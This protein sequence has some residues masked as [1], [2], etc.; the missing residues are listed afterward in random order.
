MDWWSNW[1]SKSG[2]ISIVN[3]GYSC[4]SSVGG[5]KSCCEVP[6]CMR[7]SGTAH[8]SRVFE[9]DYVPTYCLSFNLIS[10]SDLLEC[11]SR[12]SILYACGDSST[13]TSTLV[14]YYNNEIDAGRVSISIKCSRVWSITLE[15]E[16]FLATVYI[17]EVRIG[18][19]RNN[20]PS[21][22]GVSTLIG[23]PVNNGEYSGYDDMS[24]LSS[25]VG[26]YYNISGGTSTTTS[27]CAS[28]KCIYGSNGY[29]YKTFNATQLYPGP[30]CLRFHA[31]FNNFESNEYMDIRYD[32]YAGSGS[33][34][35]ARIEPTGSASN[36]WYFYALPCSA[37]ST[38]TIRFYINTN[39][40][41]AY[42][43]EVSI[44][45]GAS[46]SAEGTDT[47]GNGNSN[48][49]GGGTT[50]SNNLNWLS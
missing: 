48:T 28:S 41:Q 9:V 2:S 22:K 13:A 31:W 27:R 35:L 50:K 40:D 17:D 32:C 7:L 39:G 19:I 37:Y 36:K 18:S 26:W 30:Y 45:S 16:T 43:D 6:N 23:T 4:G 10:G 12:V 29:L 25:H 11:N 21:F 47:N 1:T 20:C 5:N 3:P 46:C 34:F 44:T 42:L 38:I 8:I 14:T 15:F 24:C 49:T 33:S